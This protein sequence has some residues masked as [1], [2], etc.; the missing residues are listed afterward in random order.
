MDKCKHCGIEGGHG[1]G[2]MPCPF[3][4]K[5]WRWFKV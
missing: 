2:S 1:R 5:R 3:R 4:V